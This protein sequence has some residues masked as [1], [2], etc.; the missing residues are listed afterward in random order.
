ML[1][2]SRLLMAATLATS[3]TL[4]ACGKDE[5]KT[6]DVLATVNGDKIYAGQVDKQ[7]TGIPPQLM[8]GHEVEVRQQLVQRLVEQSLLDQAIKTAGVEK[9]PAYKE[10][11]EQAGRQ[12]AANLLMQKK[13]DEALTPQ[14]LQQAYDAT[15]AQLTFPAVKARHILVATEAEAN[16]I[17]AEATP[18]NFADLAKSKSIGPSKDNGGELGW[19]RKE[20]M[21]PEFAKVAFNTP[22]GTIAQTPVKTQFGWHVILV[23][24]KNDKY[25]PPFEQVAPQL[26][27]QLSQQVVQGYLNELR[28]NAKITYAEGMEPQPA[29]GPAPAAQ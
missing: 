7:M 16:K 10:Q 23:E 28:Q 12:I 22:V 26:K 18:G 29:A 6:G 4:A 13:V 5:A 3:L 14:V 21:V 24:D 20:A 25:L 9:D 19:F 2:L 15:K 17:I 1:R 8:Q 27:Q 11:L